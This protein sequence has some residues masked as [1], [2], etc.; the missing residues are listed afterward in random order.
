[1][2]FTG[3]CFCI[4]GN[5]FIFLFRRPIHI[6]ITLNGLMMRNP[7]FK[8]KKLKVKP[9]V[10][11]KVKKIKFLWKGRKLYSIW[12]R[13]MRSWRWNCNKRKK[14]GTFLLFL[15]VISWAST[16]VMVFML[17]FKVNCNVWDYFSGKC[18]VF[19]IMVFLEW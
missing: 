14:I 3:C 5:G 16:I 1:M 7:I 11:K 19:V 10:G 13:K 12:W 18:F 15:F 9:M 6:V 8:G 2:T 17:L 4:C